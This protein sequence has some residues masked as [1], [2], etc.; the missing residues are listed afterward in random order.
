MGGD[1][2]SSWPVCSQRWWKTQGQ[3]KK[4]FFQ[5]YIFE[6]IGMWFQFKIRRR[7]FKRRLDLIIG[8]KGDFSNGG[9][10]VLDSDLKFPS[11]SFAHEFTKF[12]KWFFHFEDG[13]LRWN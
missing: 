3:K 5:E 7:F 4:G 10:S 12:C 13:F 8:V 2:G 9:S 11:A 6:M 1:C